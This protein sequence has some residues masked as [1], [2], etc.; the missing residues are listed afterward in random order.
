[1]PA[2]SDSEAGEHACHTAGLI[3]FQ[4]ERAMDHGGPETQEGATK[5]AFLIVELVLL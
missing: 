3:R 4:S 1:M 2:G 5:G